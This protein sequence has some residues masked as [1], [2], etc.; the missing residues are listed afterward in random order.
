MAESSEHRVKES[1][2]EHNSPATNRRNAG[3]LIRRMSD[4]FNKRK[5]P[6]IVKEHKRT[7]SESRWRAYTHAVVFI[8]RLRGDRSS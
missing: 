2:S 5:F 6:A 3:I 1:M 8:R 7:T 4:E